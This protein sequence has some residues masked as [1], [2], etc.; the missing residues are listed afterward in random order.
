MTRASA[1]LALAIALS[2]PHPLG[3]ADGAPPLPTVMIDGSSTVYPITV[4]IGERYAQE[5]TQARIEVLCSG[6]TAGFRRLIAGEIPISGASRPIRADE[7]AKAAKRGIEVVELPVA[8]DGLSVVVNKRNTFIDHLTVQELKRIWEPDSTIKTWNQVRP[9]WPKEPL[10]LFGPGRDSG[11]FDFFT[12]MVVGTAR[13]SRAD[14]T[15]SED[16]NVLVQGM[17]ASQFSLGYFGLAYL[18]EN[19]ALIKAVPI[20]AG[21]GP[22]P[23]S[24]ATVMDGTYRPLSRPLFIYVNKAA[25]ARTEV[26]QF[27]EAYLRMAARTSAEVGY[28]PLPDKV[29]Q[30]VWQRLENR[31]TGSI[32]ADSRDNT[33]LEELLLAATGA[34][35][36]KPVEA[37]RPVTD[38]VPASPPRVV[39]IAAVPPRPAATAVTAPVAAAPVAAAATTDRPTGA[40]V[41]IPRS[42][43]VLR[44]NRL[45]DSAL[46]VARLTLDERTPVAELDQRERE[47]RRLIQEL[48]GEVGGR[49]A[50]LADAA[51]LGS[52]TAPTHSELVGRLT[53]TEA[54]RGLVDD[55]VLATLKQGLLTLGDERLRAVLSLCLRR[56]SP[57]RLADFTEVLAA[58][59]TPG[60]IAPVLCYARGGFTVR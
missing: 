33:H 8:Y 19:E 32:F 39:E 16:D 34:A 28:V 7:L 41:T 45:R 4:A 48:P 40:S 17:V 43:A 6:S 3:A 59:G 23:P 2:V 25:L 27:V 50:A 26:R 55:V 38:T 1:I 11:T 56:P 49:A 53:V 24:V 46:A 36:A 20:D 51:A 9:E 54:G 52:E 21:K 13:A 29:G 18:H 57:D 42:A 10:V 35:Q 58:I 31:S 14:F 12:E 30:L 47:L 37:P 15:G 22:I 60:G 44:L 5:N